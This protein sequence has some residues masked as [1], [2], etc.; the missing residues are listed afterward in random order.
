MLLQSELTEILADQSA[1][2][3]LPTGFTKREWLKSFNPTGNHIEI[4]SGVRRSGKSTLLKWLCQQMGQTQKTVALTFEDTRLYTFEISD[5]ARLDKAIGAEIDVYFFDEI[6]NVPNWEL[7]VRQ[8]HDRG[9]KVFLSGSNATLLSKELGTRLTGRHILHTLYPLSFTEYIELNAIHAGQKNVSDYLI[10][11]GFPEFLLSNNVEVLQNL[12][13]DIV[14]RDVAI[15]YGIKS[16]D[17]LMKLTVYLMSNTGKEIT[18]NG[19]KKSFQVASANTISDY[20]HW[21]SDTYIIQLL[22]KFSWSPKKVLVNPR[23][24]YSIDTGLSKTNSLS[25]SQDYGRLFE[26]M[27]FLQ[28]RRIGSDLYYFREKQEC[29]FVA[30]ENGKCT[31]A[32]QACSILTPENL[33]R[34]VSGLLEALNY[35]NIPSGYIVTLD[36]ADVLKQGGKTIEVI[37]ASDWLRG[38]LR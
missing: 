13:K 14:M 11:G 37:K 33:G 9:K 36:Q 2:W 24:V 8:L 15:R 27:V 26:N 28:L 21:L 30:I 22:P 6:Q 7:N 3:Q 25:F 5:F 10:E 19:L 31:L 23:K 29:D 18:F 20:I 16:L 32:M 34:E 35:F 1:V 38:G 17:L 12:L 4:I